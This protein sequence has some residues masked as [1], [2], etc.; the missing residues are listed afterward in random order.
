MLLEA[1]LAGTDGLDDQLLDLLPQELHVL[2][3]LLE[4]VDR[5]LEA[6][7]DDTAR[8]HAPLAAV[9]ARLGH[10]EREARHDAVDHLV[11]MGQARQI[12]GQSRRCLAGTKAT[13]AQAAGSATRCQWLSG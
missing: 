13:L 2:A 10:L 8:S 6:A 1:R 4:V 7:L 5:L 9:S 3:L 12:S 11:W